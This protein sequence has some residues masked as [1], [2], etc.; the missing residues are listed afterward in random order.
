MYVNVQQK[1][2]NYNI[3]VDNIYVDINV[4]CKTFFKD[5]GFS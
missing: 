4:T 5:L 2:L 3:N 1:T